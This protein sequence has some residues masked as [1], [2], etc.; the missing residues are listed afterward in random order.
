MLK[1]AR[2]SI[3][4]AADK[5]G[6]SDE[7]YEELIKID[8]EYLFEIPVG[9]KKF[10]AYRVQHNNWCG[11]YKGGIRFHAD[12][13]LDEV[14]ALA[15]LMSFK[16]AAVGLPLG[17][18]KGGVTVNPKDLSLEELEELSRGYVR[19]LYKHIGPDVDVPAPD[20]NTDSRIIDWMVDEYSK[21]TGD[22]TKA[23]FTGKSIANG[24]SEGRE[25]ATGRGGVMALIE[26]LKH[27]NQNAKP[28]SVAVQGIGNV[29][30]FF[31][32][33]AQSE[34]PLKI[35]AISDSSGAVYNPDGINVD[36]VFSVKKE[37]GQV[38][39]YKETDSSISVI[40][41]QQ[42][43]ELDVDILV[44]AAL[45]NAVTDQN[46]A[47]IKAKFV[48]EL[49]NGPI[50]A[51]AQVQL[52]K[53]DI[54]VVPDIVANAGGVV[55]SYL[56]WLQNIEGEHWDENTVN[57]RLAKIMSKASRHMCVHSSE[58]GVDHKQAAFID[59]LE[60]LQKRNN[61]IQAL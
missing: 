23:S 60:H 36:D 55:V 35:V 14:R 5:L 30:Y 9:D 50:S 54:I 33:I 20:V 41:N 7:E 15:T 32:K 18:G 24:G 47:D 29:G 11:P 17:G 59:A 58:F 51:E 8:H 4:L 44:L 42:M 19:G 34:T 1:T 56:E 46:Q 49:A 43:L 12:V 28:L 31:S 39:K 27:H 52:V 6:L 21:L 25:A 45:E 26:V 38:I 37:F 22:I 53:R 48:L 57:D 61:F 40:N 2:A 10:Q 16:T 13:D 3:K